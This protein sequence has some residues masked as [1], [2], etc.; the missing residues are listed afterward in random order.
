MDAQNQ[1]T[2]AADDEDV[3]RIAMDA[4]DCL[5]ECGVTK[6]LAQLKVSDVSHLIISAALHCTILKIKSEI[7]QFMAGLDE[8]GTLH[9]I[10]EYPHLFYPMFVPSSVTAVVDSGE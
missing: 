8:A 1:L 4:C 10:K 3:R 7:D 2:G 5:F 9:A 6:P